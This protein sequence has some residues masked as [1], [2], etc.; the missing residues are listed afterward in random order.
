MDYQGNSKKQSEK[1][2]QPEGIPEKKIEKVVSGDVIQ[3][4]KPLGRRFK[5]I[6]FGGD[7]QGAA[8]Y[9]AADVLLPALRN[10]V[11]DASTKGIERIIYGES[12]PRGRRPEY[13]PRVQYH[14]PFVRR[15]DPRVV[16]ARS[17]VSLPDQPQYPFRPN[18]REANEIIIASREE[19]ELVLERMVDIIDN[20]QVASLAD[21]YELLGLPTAHTDNKWGWSNLNSASI[22]QI[23]DGYL[24]D[25]PT[26]EPL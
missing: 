2:E 10:L 4:K 20:Y 19:A 12:S 9:I 8:R 1:T 21:L 15:E 14:S 24:I 17:R 18:R 25:L 5:D 16:D 26:M 3:K 7:F 23:R 22:R 13:G 11:V 6:F